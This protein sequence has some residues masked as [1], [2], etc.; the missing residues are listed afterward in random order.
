MTESRIGAIFSEASAVH[1]ATATH[2]G[3]AILHAVQLMREAL[4]G[5]RTYSSSAMAEVLPIHSTLRPNWSGAS[6]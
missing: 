5:G 2:S 6:G 1:L 4:R 3:R